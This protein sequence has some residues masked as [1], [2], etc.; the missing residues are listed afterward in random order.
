MPIRPVG[1][2]TFG[3]APLLRALQPAPKPAPIVVPKTVGYTG[4]GWNYPL[5]NTG[6]TA[7][8][9]IPTNPSLTAGLPS[10][11]AVTQAVPTP[12][13]STTTTVR[14]PIVADYAS[15]IETDPLYQAGL[16]S[17][18][19]ALNQGALARA[20]KNRQAVIASGY[21]PGGSL[22]GTLSPYAADID[23]TTRVAA[24]ANQLSERG[25][26]EQA[27]NRGLYA[28]PYQLAARGAAGSGSQATGAT[29]LN[30][31]SQISS[32][33]ARA[34]LMAKLQGNIGDWL[35]LQQGQADRLSQLRADIANR[36]SQRAGYSESV[37]TTETGGEDGGGG[38]G[39]APYNN[40]PAPV[41]P[42]MA[43][44]TN[45]TPVAKALARTRAKTAAKRGYI[46]P[47]WGY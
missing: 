21:D 32:N 7:N 1:Y 4:S 41:N 6:R 29:A 42:R 30:E 5:G 13:T 45:M 14:T 8:Y 16:Q 26:L 28:L 15:E 27:L 40:P 24:Q 17:N 44:G 43:G 23:E 39:P 10:Q 47:S 11:A 31:Q 36:L 37:Y 3:G 35:G 9:G 33:Q 22:T 38:G 18:Q 46:T 19:G 12:R 20:E 25:Q 2:T 34:N